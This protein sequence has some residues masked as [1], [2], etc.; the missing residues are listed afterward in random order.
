METLNMS[1]GNF[2]EG[3][4]IPEFSYGLCLAKSLGEVL[5]LGSGH[6]A[7]PLISYLAR[8]PT[9]L[10]VASVEPK[11]LNALRRLGGRPGEGF[12]LKG[13]EER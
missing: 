8:K 11:E 6:V 2:S 4:Q 12:A 5:V 3:M 7:A 10:M 9:E 1:G 13:R